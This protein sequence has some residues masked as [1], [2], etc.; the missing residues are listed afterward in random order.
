ME[1]LLTDVS[2]LIEISEV[3]FGGKARGNRSKLFRLLSNRESSG[4]ESRGCSMIERERMTAEEDTI[5]FRVLV[6][7][8]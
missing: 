4:V 1:P 2:K 6:T 5:G 7:R 3:E 8:G